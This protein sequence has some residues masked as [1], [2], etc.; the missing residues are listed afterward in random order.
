MTSKT[1][2]AEAAS[3]YAPGGAPI[4][5]RQVLIAMVLFFAVII[6]ANMAMLTAAL[7]SWGGLVVKNSYV[8]SQRFTKDVSAAQA[9]PIQ[10]WSLTLTQQAAEAGA[11]PTPAMLKLA[12]A[13]GAPLTG[14]AVRL[15]VG[16]P[17]HE[18]D[19]R[20]LTLTEI[21]PGL[22]Q[23]S[24]A[25]APGAWRAE[26]IVAAAEG[27]DQRRTVRFSAPRPL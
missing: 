12:D 15:A 8:A 13:D 1:K 26:V 24:E 20:V 2:P 6:A 16:R 10:R 17:T 5:G 22:Y 11:A 27:R 23:A 25:L 4:T 3:D 7:Q 21:A 14:L 18:R 19:D 9:Q